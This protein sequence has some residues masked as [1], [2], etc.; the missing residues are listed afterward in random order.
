M[1]TVY[2]KLKNQYVFKY[3][4]LFSASFYRIEEDDQRIDET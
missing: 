2:A 1:V 3:H 4:I